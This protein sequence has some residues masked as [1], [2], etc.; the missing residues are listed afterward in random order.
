[1]PFCIAS[2]ESQQMSETPAP[3]SP[4][5][6]LQTRQ[7]RV[8]LGLL[9]AAVAL[10]YGNA[11]GNEFVFD[12]ELYILRNP[13]VTAPTPENLFAPNK[14]SN[15]YR[16][17]TFATFAANWL[18]GG[19]SPLAFHLVNLLL[20]AVVTC[21]LYFVLEKLLEPRPCARSAAFA[22]ALL[23]A[24]HPIHTEAVSS[25]VGRA[26]LLAAAFLLVAW[27]LHLA[28][29]EWAALGCLV[30]ALLSKESAVVFLPLVLVGD[31]A[32]G[33]QKPFLRY[34]R[35]A[36]VTLVYLALL[37][38]VQGGT[39]GKAS[40]SPA[41]NPL[42]A[43]PAFWRILN[44][45]GVAW[46]YVWLQLYPAELSCDYSFNAIPVYQDL[47]HT[48]PW[49]IAAGAVISVW[50]WAMLRRKTELALPLGIYIAAFAA[51]ANIL[52][53]AGTIMGERL[54]YLPSAGMCLGAGLLWTRLEQA[55]R[56]LA[57]VVLAVLVAALGTRTVVRNLDWKDNL[58]LF[59]SAV[60]VV[61]ES[62]KMRANLGYVYLQNGQMDLARRELEAALRIQPEHPNALGA[63]GLLEARAGNYQQAGALL[64]QALSRSSR[65]NPRYAFMAVSL[66]AVMIQLDMLE[67]ALEVLNREISASPGYGRA[68]ANRAVV[69]YKRGDLAA[70]RADA[71]MALRLEPDN[72]QARNLM[73]LLNAPPATEPP[74]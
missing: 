47:R 64:E 19:G 23:F 51:T 26:E 15:V 31:Y 67:G 53:P 49:A 20:H 59:S 4:P 60:R 56:R 61:P 29:R 10:A 42:V 32:T 45:L 30:P 12:D 52:M 43:L 39:F 22:S 21:L 72:P 48:V 71:E 8:F 46:K 6:P 3:T 70:A 9:L 55:Q 1:M 68:W 65:D 69:H 28:G 24:V 5:D 17:L 54:A 13:Q 40:V 35:I 36:A 7:Q 38:N 37:R 25:I 63:Y 16:P 58:A 44:A 50:V 2:Q 11:L 62:A 34:V 18:A 57:F 41:D 27:L 33:K 73:Q 74:R 66:A 14:V